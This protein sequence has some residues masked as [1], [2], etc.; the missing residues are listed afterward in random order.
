MPHI[1]ELNPLFP[2][3]SLEPKSP[4]ERLQL[5]KTEILDKAGNRSLEESKN[6][7]AERLA[8]T[9]RR[10]ARGEGRLVSARTI[11]E[12]P[13]ESREKKILDGALAY[14]TVEQ[15]A[16]ILNASDAHGN[17]AALSLAI[18]DFLERK[19]R[20]E[21]IY[22]NFSGDISSGDIEQIVPA[23]EA[24][25]GL[26]A[27]FPDEVTIETGNGDRRG[28]SLLLGYAREIAARYAPELHAYLEQTATTSI[29]AY[30]AEQKLDSQQQAGPLKTIFYGAGLA[31]LAR[32]AGAITPTAEEFNREYLKNLCAGAAGDRKSQVLSEAVGRL[33]KQTEPLRTWEKKTAES[34]TPELLKQ[35]KQIFEYW[36]LADR[37]LNEQ[38][39]LAIYNSKDAT[40]LAT[41]TGFAAGG[42]GLGEI[43]YSPR[44]YDQATW[45]KLIHPQ[46]GEKPGM[47]E[48]YGPYISFDPAAQGQMLE[49]LLPQKRPAILVV[50]HNHGN[51]TE[52]IP[53]SWGK[54]LRVENCVSSHPKRAGSKAAYVEIR[55]QALAA[56]P[57]HPENAVKFHYIKK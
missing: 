48:K 3:T 35:A 32:L 12:L 15:D 37:V 33:G 7:L 50:G 9:Q 25:A 51:F 43:A 45:N 34:L 47:V 13:A 24:L 21:K 28:A 49:Q 17:F 20:N 39:V 56:S 30:A 18:Q 8:S 19:I 14:I 23:M 1:R 55:M 57:D 11:E 10:K 29:A 38:P 40:V 44:A 54:I 41:H 27:R 26:E 5:L 36:Q 52:T 4:A 16:T 2:E 42:N 46:A 6:L 53:T 31:H 22:F